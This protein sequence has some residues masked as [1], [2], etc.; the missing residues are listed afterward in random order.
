MKRI[1]AL[2]PI[3]A[4]F[5]STICLRSRQ[6]TLKELTDQRDRCVTRAQEAQDAAAQ[7]KCLKTY[8]RLKRNL[9]C[10]EQC[11]TDEIENLCRANCYVQTRFEECMLDERVDDKSECEQT[12]TFELKEE[13]CRYDCPS[14]DEACRNACEAKVRA[15]LYDVKHTQKT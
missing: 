2:L 4:L 12:R 10:L 8:E 6:E 14:E 13:Q 5:C 7:E 1:I 11:G 15:E 9:A 3:M